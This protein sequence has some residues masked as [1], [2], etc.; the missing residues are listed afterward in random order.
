MTTRAV[1]AIAALL[2]G[3][4]LNAQSPASAELQINAALLALPAEFRADATVLGYR[5]DASGL[6]PL[7]EGTGAF[8]CLADDPADAPRF[9][10]ACY[11]RSLE[12]FM[13]RGRA[14]RAENVENV[15][16]VRYAE[17]EA[18]T[19]DMPLAPAALYSLSAEEGEPDPATGEVA[20]ARPLYVIYISGATAESTGISAQPKPGAPWLM[21]PGT[22]R[23]HIM[24]V[25]RM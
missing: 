25:P 16:S 14:L 19:L 20:G 17:I 24:F 2:L 4:P 22:P 11:H 8:I 15:D 13:A 18:G 6:V 12:A 10:V 1:L 21:F 23:A 9:H 3:T 5:A 7:R